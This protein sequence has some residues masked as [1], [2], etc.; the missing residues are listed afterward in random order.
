MEVQ[1][2]IFAAQS[3]LDH[4]EAAHFHDA[5]VFLRKKGAKVARVSGHRIND[6]L[7]DNRMLVR[8]A[9]GLGWKRS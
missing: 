2:E 7:V 5:V 3:R 4:R 6:S 8:L 9:A 1:L